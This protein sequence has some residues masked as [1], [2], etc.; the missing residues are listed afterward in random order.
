MRILL[1][2]D[3]PMM[4]A[5][6]V[7]ALDSEGH[8]TVH[9][10][11]VAE[12]FRA[13]GDDIAF[14]VALLDVELGDELSFDLAHHLGKIGLRFMFTSAR[15]PNLMPPEFSEAPYLRKPYDLAHLFRALHELGA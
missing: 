4:A 6:V 7:M 2:E 12:A 1:L 9:V 13:L 5:T 14:D 10:L 3:S 11:T 15:D 8:D